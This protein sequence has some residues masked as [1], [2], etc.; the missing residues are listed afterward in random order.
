M[1]S[2]VAVPLEALDEIADNGVADVR[3]NEPLE[4]PQQS[5]SV[6]HGVSK[7]MSSPAAMARSEDN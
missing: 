1:T 7:P 2:L 4:D 6:R 3:P 5:R